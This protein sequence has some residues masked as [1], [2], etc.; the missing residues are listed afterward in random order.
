MH[1]NAR[2]NPLNTKMAKIVTLDSANPPT[3]TNLGESKWPLFTPKTA[4]INIAQKRPLE[5]TEHKMA[6]TVT[7]D[8][9]NSLTVPN[10]GG[11]HKK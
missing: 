6:K 2:W 4:W 9:A 8:L 1:K 11:R 3:V 7:L 5:S 10:L